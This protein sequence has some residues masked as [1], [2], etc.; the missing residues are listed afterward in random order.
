MFVLLQTCTKQSKI[1]TVDVGVK[2]DIPH[3]AGVIRVK[4]IRYGTAN[5]AKLAL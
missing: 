5:M 3:D 4:K 1:V 2:Q